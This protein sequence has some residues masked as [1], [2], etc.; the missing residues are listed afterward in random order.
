MTNGCSCGIYNTLNGTS[1]FE[2]SG[3]NVGFSVVDT[4]LHSTF[5]CRDGQVK[6]FLLFTNQIS[7]SSSSSSRTDAISSLSRA[8]PV[9]S[10]STIPSQLGRKRKV[11]FPNTQRKNTKKQKICKFA[12]IKYEIIDYVND[13]DSDALI[14]LDK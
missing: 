14:L 8:N 13:N 1:I 9:A 5:Q 11:L 12:H 7:S 6:L 2:I 3:S 4:L 10:S